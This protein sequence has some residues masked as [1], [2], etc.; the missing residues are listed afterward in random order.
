MIGSDLLRAFNEYCAGGKGKCEG[1][2]IES[3]ACYSYKTLREKG[4]TLED[5]YSTFPRLEFS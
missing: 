5:F 3:S 4:R 2:L 1:E